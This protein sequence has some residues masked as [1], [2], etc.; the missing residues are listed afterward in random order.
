MI[1]LTMFCLTSSAQTYTIVDSCLAKLRG[2]SEYLTKDSSV[3][4][5]LLVG[6]ELLPSLSKA[7]IDHTMSTVFSSCLKRYLTRGELAIIIADR[8]EE[9]PIFA[10]TWYENCTGMQYCPNNP[11]HIEFYLNW[12]RSGTKTKVFQKL[13]D[14]WLLSINRNK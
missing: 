9:M 8:I 13:Y 14:D 11:N 7:F 3:I 5:L 1:L 10:L 2:S 6:K 12:I 4:N